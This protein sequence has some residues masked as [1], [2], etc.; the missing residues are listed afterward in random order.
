MKE[1][2]ER[3]VVELRSFGSDPSPEVVEDKPRWT[4]SF[5]LDFVQ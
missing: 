3:W 4:M 1:T 5:V 2:V